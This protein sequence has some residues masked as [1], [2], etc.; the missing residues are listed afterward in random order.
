MK[1]KV[2]S[3]IERKSTLYTMAE[4]HYKK[5]NIQGKLQKKKRK[6][7]HKILI[8]SLGGGRSS[9][10]LG[11]EAEASLASGSASLDL[12]STSF[13]LVAASLAS[14]WGLVSLLLPLSLATSAL[15]PWSLAWLGPLEASRGGRVAWTVK[16]YLEDSGAR[17]EEM[18]G[19]L[20]L[21]VSQDDSRHSVAASITSKQEPL[22]GWGLHPFYL[23]VVPAY[24]S[25][26]F[27]QPY[28]CL[29]DPKE[30]GCLL[31]CLP[32]FLNHPNG[33]FGLL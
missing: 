27:S 13:A 17:A 23:A 22:Q 5:E 2:S 4:C 8:L 30:V 11:W 9:F 33:G 21:H 25:Q 32:S 15:W 20:G 19:Q 7:K 29:L 28:L 12:N 24:L 16:S 3:L 6:I 10:L 14:E 31:Q 18:G 1:S 26:L